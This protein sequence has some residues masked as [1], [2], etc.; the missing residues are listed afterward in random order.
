MISEC[1]Q[2]CGV[3][4]KWN[5]SVIQSNAFWCIDNITVSSDSSSMPINRRDTDQ[6]EPEAIAYVQK[7]QTVTEC[8]LYYD[9]FDNGTY[10]TAL[11]SDISGGSVTLRPCG[12]SLDSHYWVYFA[13]TDIRT[14]MTQPL[15]LQNFNSITFNLL[16]R[17]RSCSSPSSNETMWVEYR[18]GSSGSW[19]VI[20]SYNSTCCM[21]ELQQN[22]YL[23][24][25]AQVSNVYLR[26]HQ[27][28]YTP[29]NI[30]AID[31]VKIGAVNVS[32]LYEDLFYNIFNPTIWLSVNGGGV[33][34]NYCG[35]ANAL[36]F[37]QSFKRQAVT[38]HF[39]LW[40][41]ESFSISFNLGAGSCEH[42]ESGEDVEVSWRTDNGVWSILDHFPYSFYQYSKLIYM[43]PYNVAGIN[44]VQFRI[45]QIVLGNE[46]YDIWFIDNFKIYSFNTSSCLIAPT[47]TMTPP[48]VSPVCNYYFDNFDDQTYK[49]SL[50]YTVDG[51]VVSSSSCGTTPINHFA[52]QLS[53]SY[54]PTSQLITQ[55]L[56]LRGVESISFYLRVCN[57]HNNYPMFSVSYSI[58]GSGIFHT[59]ESYRSGCCINAKTIT[60]HLPKEAQVTLVQ[61]RW[62]YSPR[63]SRER[64]IVDDIIIGESVSSI[65][66]HD[67]FTGISTS[68]WSSV[69]GGGID[70][71]VI[72]EGTALH[73]SQEGFRE[74]I[75]QFLDLRQAN[76]I[77]F[78]IRPP[79]NGV[80][81]SIRAGHGPWR[82]IQNI[83][84]WYVYVDIPE[85]MKV[86]SA[87]LRWMQNIPGISGNDVWTVDSLRILNINSKTLCST[88]CFF[89]TFESGTYNMSL[90]DFV[91]GG[92]TAIPPCSVRSLTMSIYFNQSGVRQAV[93][94][95]LDLR[96]MYA[97][98]FYLQV[99]QNDSCTIISNENIIIFYSINSG[100]TWIEIMSYPSGLYE[101][102]TLVTV[103][104]PFRARDQSVMLRLAQPTYSISVW[105]LGNFGIYSPDQCPPLSVAETTTVIPPTPTPSM[106]TDNHCNYFLDNFDSGYLKD[107][108][109]S[110][111]SSVRVI[112]QIG[113]SCYGGLSSKNYI[114][115]FSTRGDELITQEL[116][117]HGVESFR[118]DLRY[119]RC[120]SGRFYSSSIFLYYRIGSTLT[121]N[122]LKHFSYTCCA[123]WNNVVIH[124]PSF[125]QTSSVYL[126]WYLTQN[127]AWILDNVQFGETVETVLYSDDFSG[128]YDPSLWLIIVGASVQTPLCSTFTDSVL[129]FSQ[130]GS[131]EAV[132]KVLDLRDASGISFYLRIGYCDHAEVGED[133]EL[134]YRINQS[135][136]VTLQTMSSSNFRT[137]SYVYIDVEESLQVRS[138]QL[139]FRQRVLAFSSYDTW[140]IDQFSIHSRQKDTKCSVACYSDNFNS[141]SLNSELWSS[142][143]VASVTIPPCSDDYY[144]NSLY[145]TDGGTREAVTNSLDLR[146]L[147]AISFTLQIGSFDND[148]DQAE[149]RENVV[150]YYLSLDNSNWVELETFTATAYTRA[151]S[152]T[153][154][155][156][157]EARM[158]GVTLRW[159]QLQHSGVLQD[160]WFIDDVGIYSPNECPPTAYQ[161]ASMPTPESV[162]PTPQNTKACNYYFDNFDSGSYKRS[163][164][165]T[166]VGEVVSLPSCLPSKYAFKFTISSGQLVTRLLDLRGVESIT[167]YYDAY[168]YSY[169]CYQRTTGNLCVS[170][171][172]GGGGIWNTL[173]CYSTRNNVTLYLPAE[174]QINMVQ[175][176]WLLT[177]NSVDTIL[178]DI[179][180]GN[181][182]HTL[183]YQDTFT[184][185]LSTTLWSS[186][187]GA[188]ITTIACGVI[189]QGTALYFTGNGIREAVTQFLDLHQA[190]AVS[191]Y[192]KSNCMGLDS[193]ETVE[194]SIRA[195]HGP[196]RTL[197]TINNVDTTYF[198]VDIPEDMKVHSAQLRWIQNVPAL[199]WR[200][201]WAI[202]SLEVHSTYPSTICSTS[203]VSDNFVSGTYN[204]SVWSIISGAQVTRPPCN[205]WSQSMSL[206]FNQS[207]VRQAVTHPLDLRGMYAI[208]FYL[209][210]VQYDEVC[211]TVNNE[212]VTVSYSFIN[213]NHW[214]EINSFTGSQFTAETF[215]TVSIPPEAR[216]HS[217]ILRLAQPIYSSSVWSINNFGIYSPDQCPPLSVGETTAIILPTPTPATS[218][219]LTCNY[220]WD[221]FASGFY[222]DTLWSSFVGVQIARS[223]CGLIAQQYAVQFVYTT[224]EIITQELDLRGVEVIKFF[225]MSGRGTSSD[226][227]GCY[228][229]QSDGGMYVS[230]RVA[231]S[232]VWNT[233][234]YFQYYCCFN[235]INVTI[236]IPTAVQ[237]SSVFLRWSQSNY[238][239]GRADWVLGNI[240]IGSAIQTELYS[241]EFTGDYDSSLWS[242]VLGGSVMMPPCGTTYSG[243]ALYFSQAGKREAIT[244][245]LDLSQAKSLSFYLRIG[246]TDNCD[247]AEIGEDILLSYRVNRSPWTTLKTFL[248]TGYRE[249]LYIY[250]SID[251]SLKVNNIQFQFKQQVLTSSSYDT[252]SIDQFVIRTLEKDTKCSL[253]CYSDNFNSGSLNSELWSSVVVA[254]VTIPP[255]SDDYHGNSLY[256]TDGGTREAVTNSLDL[257]GLYAISFTLQIGSFDNDCDQAEAGDEVVL[258]YLT[259]DRS[260]WVEL[261][262]FAATAY[263]RATRVTVP[264]PREIQM[265]DVTLRWA[266]LQHSGLLQDTWFID[267]V[268]IFSPN[269]CPPIRHQIPQQNVTVVS[270]LPR[271]ILTCNYYSDNFND[272]SYKSD[273]WRTVNNIRILSSL[274]NFQL[275]KHYG[276]EFF[277]SESELT[278]RILD[279]RGVKYIK[280]YLLSGS[281][282]RSACPVTT[283][284]V[285]SFAVSYRLNGAGLWHVLED[286]AS[287][288]C[289]NGTTMTI[290]LPI[291][292]Q[293]SAVQLKWMQ[294][295]YQG[296]V[297]DD[298]EI[299]N[300]LETVLYE[301]SFTVNINSALW[302]SVS[303]AYVGL[304][305]CG[306]TDSGPA[307]FFSGSGIREAITVFLD[308]RQATSISFYLRIGSS[309]SSCE[310]ADNAE[311]IEIFYRREAGSWIQFETF[312]SIMYRTAKYVHIE[313]SEQMKFH[314]VQ[315]RISQAL[316]AAALYDVWSIDTFTVHSMVQ[317]P[318]CSEACYVDNFYTEYNTS[319]WSRVT[320]GSVL[321]LTCSTDDRYMNGIY[322]NGSY[323]RSV[324]TNVLNLDGLYAISF[325]LQVV[326]D[327]NACSLSPSGEDV[328]V[329]Y[330]VNSGNWNEF[331]RFRSEDY[332]QHTDV[333]VQLP[334][335][336]RH[337]NT[338]IRIM[339]PN[340]LQ[341]V[342][343]I[344]NF[345]IFSPNTCP[346]INYVSL[347]APISPT[348]LPYPH[349]TN[350]TICNYYSDN[351]DSGVYNASLW[352]TV[353]GVRIAL[354]PCGLSHLL[355]YA[356]QFYSFRTRYVITD[357]LDLRGVEYIQFY[358]L[359]GSNSNGCSA[360]ANNEG[361]QVAYA[362]SDSSYFTNL[363]YFAPSCCTSGRYV[364]L[365]LPS[366]AQTTSVSIRWYQYTTTYINND[367]AW[368]LDDVQIGYT[369][370]DVFYED[371]FTNTVNNA[372]WFSVEGASVLTPPC[373]VTHS[374]H[375]L[376]FSAN[377]TR[378]AI[379]QQLDLRH[380][381][382]LS[383]YLRTGSHDGTC[384][385]SDDIEDI[386]LL[387]RIN[388]GS[389]MLLNMYGYYRDPRYVYISL[390]ENMQVTGAQFRLMQNSAPSSNVDV[391]SIDDFIIH[392]MIA[393]TQC[394][395]AC[396][397][398]DF[399]NGQ[400]S[401][402]L[403]SSV[404]GATIK[405]PPCS[406]QYLGNALYFE[407]GG[408]RQ[409]I[410]RA[411]D[412]RGLYALS[413]YLHIGSFGGS[414]APAES[415]EDVNLHYRY[416]NSSSWTLLKSYDVTAY[417]RETRITEPIPRSI[418]QSGIIFRWMQAS[419]SGAEDDTW[420]LDNVGFHSPNDC[421][422]SGYG[423]H[424]SEVSVTPT[425][426]TSSSL[427]TSFT[428]SFNPSIIQSLMQS[429]T[430]ISSTAMSTS[431]MVSSSI[432]TESLSVPSIPS[433]SISVME[434]MPTPSPI[435][436]SC[437]ETFDQLNDGVYRQGNIHILF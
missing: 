265:Q 11:W 255:C 87:Q 169:R 187:V 100:T 222:K 412:L 358:L 300:V 238:I 382:A 385:S 204:T 269:E 101:T 304:P 305:P 61:L 24:V 91:S 172:I 112:P 424:G 152:V 36:F 395:L 418:R 71:S 13:G 106:P 109:W 77:S 397:S 292:V 107:T 408:V 51:A 436:D 419:H 7:R 373:G 307:L 157:R 5:F 245:L 183:L 274:C 94:L 206:Y 133:I 298:V 210:V 381:T 176:R 261:E 56:D 243:N 44:N 119:T 283:T 72:D 208:S 104:L 393:D 79:I 342:W 275:V 57:V 150:L 199:R 290:H 429:T 301:D 277:S 41:T 226:Y 403:W 163:L 388:L 405:I 203:C 242:S 437:V 105:S 325:G 270:S 279:L 328:F 118:F 326:L 200:D 139:H 376:Y 276:A 115:V 9:N 211:S 181:A 45:S 367:D 343:S 366:A 120:Y 197:Q 404:D 58:A 49:T 95:P 230:Y 205:I 143:V 63:S 239:S 357:P 6:N 252:W 225:L 111:F 364:R 167:F 383:F 313:V 237:V 12:A 410:T 21:N 80:E 182:V 96:G 65:L 81:L 253:A 406:N 227:H 164:W 322:F 413:F 371:H 337:P 90:W 284:L 25:A 1:M 379:T 287:D 52:M 136:W 268:G 86:Y 89:D 232:V 319:L 18:V 40:E 359:S 123:T 317:S 411:L 351:F 254:S 114:V 33:L 76:A 278:T 288:C 37:D 162:S 384:E 3:Q 39:D 389:W 73:F 352:S 92:H 428:T 348:P 318:E 102:E 346:P 308:L 240:E 196:W 84:T 147:Y 4:L 116:N 66:Y 251:E 42:S 399:N 415:G 372:L 414:C 295:S 20:E 332:H 422:P 165:Q 137:L 321:L 394:T 256:F 134:S 347:P 173:E 34:P 19:V 177:G 235:L 145:F 361:M 349:P 398:D 55:L 98:S 350:N 362:V 8:R 110:T 178:D 160:T 108:L 168:T 217:V 124:I 75:T 336:A 421:P 378:Q 83:N 179:V 401:I 170:Y 129:Y 427:T 38:Q 293:V 375:A 246:S 67:D 247:Q 370:D 85:D 327:N 113:S 10:N 345:G 311:N 93:T 354:Q 153:V 35:V 296:W 122:F 47:P 323:E 207:G 97:V 43:G 148:C 338:S 416:F 32:L 146:G 128:S 377:G 69:F 188:S 184:N 315:L 149:A 244:Q 263:T 198:H 219:D 154:P 220:Y 131:R 363:E 420:S 248:A 402:Q 259:S 435:L 53:S 59:L 266:Q 250:I 2:T 330:S 329:S 209:Q 29:L 386:S 214:V 54:G 320:G 31:E 189:D 368:I 121:W 339:Q 400:Y 140:S 132:T 302:S 60:L 99:V 174:V 365:Y 186:V 334:I 194:L 228:R 185:H 431:Q 281:T 130:G 141:G 103:P 423:T 380:A 117:L 267:D 23:P 17:S 271:N 249:S 64:W 282:I 28:G 374:S 175:L 324:I 306:A 30:W 212:N 191:F 390:T 291:A 425:T 138:V 22:A 78:Y 88:A 356:M 221:D 285:K 294:L 224:R 166:V 62:L 236:H 142:V 331:K 151:T 192:F 241:D 223:P 299:G 15:D 355:H 135:N 50:W 195:G 161:A 273:L 434:P 74:A 417:I 396:Y 193:E 125:L 333:V 26:W 316:L 229:P 369:V 171:S 126:R 262:M 159:A 155:I 260:N 272:G 48:S 231:S 289:R 201:V 213:D 312:S 314:D 409:A 14:I 407:G 341:S 430:T 426:V 216:N 46:N 70:N 433:P 257:R 127:A 303:G 218:S 156:P 258:Y 144:G 387:W 180:I 340:H 280:F 234:E 391:W 215:V 68:L 432:V 392:N 310:S 202:D 353:T 190:N 309:D 233:L 360:P 82:T 158:Q 16:F 286:Y 344:D 335:H 297:L 264:I 27:S